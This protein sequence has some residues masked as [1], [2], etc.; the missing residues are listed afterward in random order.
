MY[1]EV[2]QIRVRASVG[3][4]QGLGA[5]VMLALGYRKGYGVCKGLDEFRK[6]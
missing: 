1:K 2:F 5:N 4:K 3:E 6:G